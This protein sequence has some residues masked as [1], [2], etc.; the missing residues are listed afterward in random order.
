[1]TH[2][3]V[4]TSQSSDFDGSKGIISITGVRWR[5]D[6]RERGGGGGVKN[7]YMERERE[8]EGVCRRV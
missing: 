7:M 2:Q 4:Y 6:E 8:R 1:M 3:K 5:G